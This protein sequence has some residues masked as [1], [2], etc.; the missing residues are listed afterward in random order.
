MAGSFPT[1]ANFATGDVLSAQNMNDLA[2]TVNLLQSSYESA[3]GVNKIIN[4]DFGIWQRGTSFTPATSTFGVY[5]ADRW[6]WR[7]TGTGVTNTATQQTFTPGTAPVSGYEGNFFMRCATTV[8]GTGSTT[9]YI[10]QAIEDVRTFAGQTVTISFWAKVNTGTRVC[11]AN[12]IQYFGTGGSADVNGTPQDFTATTSWTRYSFTFS[13]ASITGKT[14]GTGSYLEPRINFPM[15]TVMELD[16]WGVQV[17]QSPVAS[18]FKTATGTK[19]AELAACQRYYQRLD[20]TT[21]A[22]AQIGLCAFYSTTAAKGQIN[23]PVNLRIAPTAIDWS[24]VQLVD[25]SSTTF[26]PSA[27]TLATCTNTTIGFDATVTGATQHRPGW[28]RLTATTGFIA[29]TAEL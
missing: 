2:D 17:E 27:I 16:L 14:I 15:N 6:R 18:D 19:Q 26:T 13:I 5:L 3:A 10:S 8:A 23:L 29:F 25:T 1:K 24:S 7:Y 28:F 12:F 4:G 21:T 20:N 9:N 11:S 22:N